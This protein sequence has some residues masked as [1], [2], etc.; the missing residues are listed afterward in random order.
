M[1]SIRSLLFDPPERARVPPRRD[2][3]P[4]PLE[5]VPPP[6]GYAP[7]PGEFAAPPGS[8]LPP[9]GEYAPAPGGYVP[10]GVEEPP[11]PPPPHVAHRDEYVAPRAEVR[12]RRTRQPLPEPADDSSHRG[13]WALAVLGILVLALG[14][15][16]WGIKSGLPYAYN[17]DEN[18]HFVPRAIGLFGHNLNPQYFN[19]PPAYTYLL[20]IVY[21]IWY[22]GGNALSHTFASNPTEVWVIARATAAV[23]GTL[24]VWLLYLCGA[25]LFDRRT[26]LLAAGL[27]AVAFL[28][29]FYAH[30]AL[31]D[32]PTLAP[33]TLSLWATAG[34]LRY[35]RMRDYVIAGIGLGL[36]SATKYTG[37]IVILPL[38]AAGIYHYRSSGGSRTALVG[39]ATAGALG[40]IAFIFADPYAVLDF[41]AFHSGIVHQSTASDDSTG[42]LGLTHGSGI[43]YYLWTLTWGLGW[44]PALAA[45]GGTIALWWKER[46]LIVVL[47]PAVIVFLLFMGLQGR[48]FG[49][50]LMPVLP[51]FCL[52]SAFAVLRAAD[53]I[54]S[55]V[56]ELR[57]TMVAL[58]VV[59]LCGQGVVHSVHSGL[60][61]S[62]PD[63]RNEARA[64]MVANVPVGAHIVVEPVVPDQWASD[65]GHVYA[66][67][68]NGAHWIK[69]PAT[70]TQ[71]NSAGVLAMGAGPVV[72]IED[73][74]KTL[75]PALIPLYE[76]HGYCYVIT[77]ETQFGRAEVDPSQVPGA[78][79]YYKALAQQAKLVYT[80]TPYGPKGKPV[81][82]NFDWTFDY[83]PLSYS[84]PG[85]VMNIYHLTGGRC[86]QAPAP[87]SS[88]S[89]LPLPSTGG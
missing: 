58:A 7:P 65:I 5:Y 33:L 88:I 60:V 3:V 25:R 9:A 76:E 35:G 54:G 61:D 4:P 84:N 83:Y 28:P 66:T 89:G 15:R 64:Y 67:T 38:A 40:L 77:G 87:T 2:Y 59:G 50:W 23:L 53:W 80:A 46:R 20:Y 31:N 68:A 42:K 11:P 71:V 57:P 55:L 27:M 74:E 13:R 44:V 30:L 63:T 10:P 43:T 82:F 47:A 19:N 24:A 34:V 22:G 37:G 85:P 45:L 8:Y 72:N 21:A 16:L 29:V 6:G 41:S 62:R 86:A 69:F 79:A 75:Q 51:I 26:G 12:P 52:L 1:R 73:Y 36:A 18:A 14:L 32:V 39:I 81:R 49:R 70:H 56:P 78:I 17:S 48:Y